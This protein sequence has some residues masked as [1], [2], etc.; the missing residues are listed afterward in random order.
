MFQESKILFYSGFKTFIHVV[1]GFYAI[2]K[3]GL[4]I[5]MVIARVPL[6]T[7]NL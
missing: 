4:K 2:V 3:G 7:F 1:I 5:V 6:G